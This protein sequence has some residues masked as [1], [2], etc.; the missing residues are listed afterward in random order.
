M[1]GTSNCH[2]RRTEKPRH[3]ARSLLYSRRTRRFGIGINPDFPCCRRALGTFL[4]PFF[5][6]FRSL[7]RIFNLWRRS[8]RIVAGKLQSPG[9]KCLDQLRF[10]RRSLVQSFNLCPMPASGYHQNDAYDHDDT[11]S[12]EIVDFRL[13]VLP[14]NRGLWHATNHFEYSCHEPSVITSF[15]N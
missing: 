10:V 4:R 6:G 13:P 5:Q 12:P 15:D 8:I 7:C 1:Y 2:V 9:G 3:A 14:V 11:A